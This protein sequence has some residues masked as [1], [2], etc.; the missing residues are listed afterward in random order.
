MKPSVEVHA[1]SVTIM[2][3]GASMENT[4]LF[5]RA[6]F[7]FLVLVVTT[8]LLPAVLMPTAAQAA[9][10]ND[11]L[12]CYVVGTPPNE[13]IECDEVGNLRAQCKLMD[14]KPGELEVCDDVNAKLIMPMSLSGVGDGGG[15]PGKS[16]TPPGLGFTTTPS[17][18]N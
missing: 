18:L 9:L 15:T 17:R 8:M 5:P 2:S 12:Y 10:N 14:A 7:P 6:A 1:A 11:D 13:D 3:T 16:L 4:M